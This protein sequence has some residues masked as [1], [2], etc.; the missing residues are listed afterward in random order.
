MKVL[1]YLEVKLDEL[2]IYNVTLSIIFGQALAFIF[3][4][5]NPNLSSFFALNS[6]P[7][8]SHKFIQIFLFIFK[9][10]SK[11]I[12]YTALGLY[13]FYIY[14]V[15]LE[16]LWGSGK[17]LLYIM[18][19]WLSTVL[20]SLLFPSQI[21]DNNLFFVSLF[22]AFANLFPEMKLLLFFIIP[23]RV[24]WLGYLTWAGLLLSIF[25]NGPVS[26]LFILA[27]LANFFIFFA[28]DIWDF[29]K[30]MM[31]KNRKSNLISKPLKLL[32]KPQHI[33]KICGKNEI[34]NPDMGIRYCK[35]CVP[36]TC[37]CEDHVKEHEHV[38]AT[39]N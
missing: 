14:G 8:L 39:I 18:L 19:F 12:L 27:Q 10:Y 17:Y 13:I 32:I 2:N 38:S 7:A 33:C 36:S 25:A 26:F 11:D 20:L 21:F 34:E 9:P 31:L 22:L 28:H 1:N 37:Y 4:T 16:K 6:T 29:I 15:S 3:L 23:V 24:K 30:T 35:K 5:V